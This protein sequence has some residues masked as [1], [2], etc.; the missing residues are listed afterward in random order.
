VTDRKAQG[1]CSFKARHSKCVGFYSEA[2]PMC[3][4]RFI[5]KHFGADSFELKADTAPQMRH[6]GNY[7][8]AD[9]GTVMQ[10]K[11]NASQIAL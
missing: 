11:E 1:H 6:N 8:C 10:A 2:V 3:T 9:C 5:P 7:R 4:S